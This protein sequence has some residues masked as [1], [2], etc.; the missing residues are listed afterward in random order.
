MLPLPVCTVLVLCRD[1][2][3]EVFHTFEWYLI[4]GM[5]LYNVFC[6]MLLL[7]DTRALFWIFYLPS[8]LV[9]TLVDAYPSHYRTCFERVF[10]IVNGAVLVAWV[11]VLSFGFI[12]IHSSMWSL[13]KVSGTL[14]QGC[15]TNVGMLLAFVFRHL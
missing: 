12:E 6:A 15:V 1:L 2:L 8:V 7:R 9:S 13:A 3:R 10:F 5:Q 11:V 4:V 14:L